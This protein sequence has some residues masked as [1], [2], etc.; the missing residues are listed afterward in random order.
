MSRESSAPR[1]RWGVWIVACALAL[2]LFNAAKPVHIDDPFTLAIADQIRQAPLDP[3]GFDIFWLQWPQPVHEELTPPLLPYW[4]AGASLLVGEPL[5]PASVVGLKL[6]LL[7]FALLLCWALARLAER[8]APGDGLRWMAALV[9]S[10]AILPGFNLMQDVP[11]LALG[12]GGLAVFVGPRGRPPGWRAILLA[13]LLCGLAVQT[14]YTAFGPLGAVAV[15]G[16]LARRRLHVVLAFAV[17]LGLFFGWEAFT[18]ARYGSGM[19]AGQ[20]GT[21]MFWVPRERMV[22][23]LLRLLGGAAPALAVVG[24]AGAGGVRWG[25]PALAGLITAAFFAIGVIDLAAPLT[26]ILGTVSVVTLPWALWLRF[27]RGHGVGEAISAAPSQTQSEA[28][29]LDERRVWFAF[30]L[31]WLVGEVVL[32]FLAAPFP[33]VRRVVGC[34]VAATLLAARVGA[35]RPQ[36]AGTL[37]ACWVAT[38]AVGLLVAGVDFAEA[39]LQ[40][41]GARRAVARCSESGSKSVHFLG[42][43]GFQYYAEAAGARPLIPD[44]PPRV[45]AGDCVVLPTGVDRQE[46]LLPQ[47]S[48]Q[49]LEQARYDGPAG[50]STGHGY[51]GGSLALSR[52]RGPSLR[53]DVHQVVAPFDPIGAWPVQRVVNWARRYRGATAA[54]AAPALLGFL[55]RG[56]EPEREDAVR[57]LVAIA[58]D[59]P[60]LAPQLRLLLDDANPTVRLGAL[61]ALSRLPG[62][63]LPQATLQRLGGDSDPDVASTARGLLDRRAPG[64]GRPG[65]R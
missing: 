56:S 20:L 48:L 19:L 55:Q 30:L 58:A 31:L 63:E 61:L 28:D 36:L 24:L 7:P 16:L 41:R 1:S 29:S 34:A 3:Y 33:A 62:E 47:S 46:V 17:A 39:S 38:V 32:F 13:G 8:V 40:R 5:R 59:A 25:R 6:S 60:A 53:V 49:P 42:H 52:R 45:E 50:W 21:S 14:K 9:L 65:A 15:W 23:P 26:T 57:G 44:R 11:A 43:W 54:A 22:L 4:L 51:Y 27:R 12:L 10:P 37:R 18:T 35:G 64:P 2:T